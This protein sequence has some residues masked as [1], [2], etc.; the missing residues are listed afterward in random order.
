MDEQARAATGVLAGGRLL[1]GASFCLA[2]S[3]AARWVGDAAQAP[4]A[5][6]VIRALGARDAALGL[7]TLASLHQPV[8]LRRWLIL[9]SACDATDFVATLAGPAAP[10]RSAVAAMAAGAAVAGVGL[11]AAASR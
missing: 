5:R 8:Q 4:G 3:L 6:M 2:P 7:G 1:I 11:A 10:A 9:S